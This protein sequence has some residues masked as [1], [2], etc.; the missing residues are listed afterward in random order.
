MKPLNRLFATPD[1]AAR[2]V[3]TI[4]K[5]LDAG[6]YLCADR[7]GRLFPAHSTAS[8]PLGAIVVVAA[9]Q[10]TGHAGTIQTFEV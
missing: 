5:R 1:P 8:Y 9:G 6:R 10:I 4:K 2:R 7:E 3:V